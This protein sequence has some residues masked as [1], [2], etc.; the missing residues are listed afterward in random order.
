MSVDVDDEF[1]YT[2]PP[3]AAAAPASSTV[4][5][6]TRAP[7]VN[8]G[9]T[10]SPLWRR[11]PDGNTVCNA[12]GESILLISRV[13]LSLLVSLLVLSFCFFFFPNFWLQFRVSSL[14]MF[15]APMSEVVYFELGCSVG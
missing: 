7:C 3:S 8:C 11:D 5:A 10:E 9:V 15:G 4:L 13:L 14:S 2:P 1:S 12:C 6:P